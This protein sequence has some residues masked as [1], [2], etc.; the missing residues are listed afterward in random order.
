MNAQQQQKAIKALEEKKAKEHKQ[1][2]SMLFHT[3]AF[4]QLHCMGVMLPY[5]AL[6]GLEK[7][8]Y[9]GTLKEVLPNKF[10]PHPAI[11][12]KTKWS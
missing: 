10:Y 5:R 6:Y 2:L 8:V 4:T 3:G 12:L 11:T 7:Q 1:F 9:E